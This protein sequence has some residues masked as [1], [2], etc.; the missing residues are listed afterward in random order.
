MLPRLPRCV[1][2][3]E[4]RSADATGSDGDTRSGHRQHRWPRR[5]WRERGLGPLAS[6]DTLN[7]QAEP[8]E[9]GSS[10][11]ACP[12]VDYRCQLR[13]GESSNLRAVSR[14]A[15]PIDQR[16]PGE[17]R[18]PF[19]RRRQRAP[20]REQRTGGSIRAG[21]CATFASHPVG[22]RA[23][24]LPVLSRRWTTR[25]PALPRLEGPARFNVSRS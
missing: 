23:G 6:H 15:R 14:T 9:A 12:S 16:L 20:D 17:E 24:P 22:T 1:T 11:G 21:Q 13:L 25:S 3:A 10:C 8:T 5:C 7:E 19:D 2:V 4:F 18:L